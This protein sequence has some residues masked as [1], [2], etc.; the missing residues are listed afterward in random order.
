MVDD[1]RRTAED[2]T[3][4]ARYAKDHDPAVRE[5]LVERFM[6]LARRLAMRYQQSGEPLEDLV[7]VQI[8]RPDQGS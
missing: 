3:L 1:Q 8:T 5:Q 6:P 7:Q 4:F 2:R